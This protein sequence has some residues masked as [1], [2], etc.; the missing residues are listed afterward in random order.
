MVK[1]NL[2][3]DAFNSL[4]ELQ[5]LNGVPTETYYSK[6]AIVTEMECAITHVIEDQL[7][8]NI[9]SSPY[10]GVMLDETC[11]ISI[12]KKLVDYIRY[13]KSGKSQVAYVG[14]EKISDCTAEGIKTALTSFLRNKGLMT[15][16]DLS[17][18]MGLRTDGALV[19]VGY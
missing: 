5:K 7:F 17:K 11:D 1:N 15:D 16:D 14:N 8:K 19:M 18:V 13:I 9:K 3:A 6:P 2:P 10:I 12:D 4:M